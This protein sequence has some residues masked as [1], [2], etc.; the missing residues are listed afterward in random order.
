MFVKPSTY[1]KLRRPIRRIML[2]TKYDLET[3]EGEEPTYRFMNSI[4]R[5]D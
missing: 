3:K 5:L 2:R 1:Q 4:M